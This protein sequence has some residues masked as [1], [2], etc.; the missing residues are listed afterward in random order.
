MEPLEEPLVASVA[1]QEEDLATLT[2]LV[3]HHEHSMTLVAVL[4][5][6]VVNWMANSMLATF[7]PQVFVA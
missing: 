7:F 5:V 6:T 4:S 3:C 1:N 2:E